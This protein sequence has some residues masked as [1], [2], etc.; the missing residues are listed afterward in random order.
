M[1]GNHEV[2]KRGNIKKTSSCSCDLFVDMAWKAVPEEMVQR[3]FKKCSI[4]NAM[5]GNEDH[6]LFD[7]EVAEVLIKESLDDNGEP[8]ED[9]DMD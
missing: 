7:D 2:T 8:E 3:S 9:P 6:L 4:S 1:A 5:D